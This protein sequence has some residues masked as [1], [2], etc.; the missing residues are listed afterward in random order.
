MSDQTAAG[1]AAPAAAPSDVTISPD[2]RRVLQDLA[3][4]VAEIAAR[5][6]EQAKRE[7]W[8]QHNALQPTRPLIFCDP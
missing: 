5:P 2:E 4:R 1:Q 8:Y 6:I 7:L 3:T